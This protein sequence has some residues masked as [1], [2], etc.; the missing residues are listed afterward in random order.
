[1]RL[2]IIYLVCVLFVICPVPKLYSYSVL[3]HEAIVDSVWKDSIEPMLKKRF[4]RA[5]DRDLKMAHAYA[6]GGSIIQDMGYYPFGSKFFTDLTHYVRSG[7][8]VAMM[9]RDSV[10][11]GEYAF[12]LGALAHYASDTNGHPLG[13]NRAVPLLYP[14]L[15]RKYG[16]TVTYEDNPSAHLKTEFGFDVLQVAKGRFAPDAYRDFIGFEVAKPLLQRSFQHTYGL[17]LDDV[18]GTLDLAIG[19]YRRTVS[20][21]IP[22][23]TQVAWDMK[24]DD[25]QKSQ[26]GITREKFLYNLS[27]ADYE[28]N[29]GTQYE[30]PGFGTRTLATFIQ[31]L[32]KVGPLRVLTFRTPTPEAE[33]LFMESFNSTVERYRSQLVAE[34][35]RRTQPADLNLDVGSPSAAGM[36]KMSDD[37]YAKLVDKLAKHEF[38]SIP[39]DLRDNILSFYNDGEAPIATKRNRRHWAKLQTELETLRKGT[40]DSA[41]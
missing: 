37:A 39:P 35:S 38:A 18:F 32:P 31:I 36:Y 19:T 11:L 8:F 4:P 28:K 17:D 6:Y 41:R 34:Q 24:Q 33:K 16:E 1:M 7:D 2:R 13:T 20:S 21:L 12:A 10:S 5:T 30:A 3:S 27:R 25:I 29:W 40:A 22:K 9:L 14:K 23:I 15:Q 26:P